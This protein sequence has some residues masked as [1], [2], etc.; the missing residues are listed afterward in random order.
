MSVYLFPGQGSQV[1]GMGSNLFHQFSE[2]TSIAETI[3]GYSIENLC[4]NDPE[5]HLNFT[6]YTQPALYTVNA[7]AYYKKLQETK[8]QPHFV[9]GHSL[10]EYNALLAA[11]VFDFATGLRLVK[12][13][14]ELMAQETNG[15]MIAVIG[16][17][18]NAIKNVLAQNHLDNLVIG[19]HNS[20]TQVVISGP[21]NDIVQAQK[22]CEQL[23]STIVIPLKVSGAFHS[24]YMKQAQEQFEIFL[25]D[26][27]FSAPKLPVISNYTAQAYL[28]TNITYNLTR[29]ITHPVR[30]TDTIEYLLGLG[31]TEFE[32][33][34]PGFIL[35]GIINR[36][37]NGQ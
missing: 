13:R 1:K 27:Q 15:A 29:Q 26:F 16:L 10:G 28:P 18:I 6:Q 2:L 36:I 37:K 20:H 31:E 21:K 19:N 35:S 34:G 22:I 14:G 11:E 30:W 25:K 9:A 12:K 17:K 23:G 7:L 8:K 4:L 24:P 33:I 32:E 5:Q 3:L